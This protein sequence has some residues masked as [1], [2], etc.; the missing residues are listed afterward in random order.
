[1]LRSRTDQVLRDIA[2]GNFRQLAQYY[3]PGAEVD[4]RSEIEYHLGGPFGNVNLYSWT[5]AAIGVELSDDGRHARTGVEVI[6]QGPRNELYKK[7]ILFTWSRSD[8]TREM[9]FY[10]LPNAS[11]TP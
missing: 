4:L 3:A 7:G 2:V 11:A 10:L 5:A 6:L 1:M 9:T 8:D